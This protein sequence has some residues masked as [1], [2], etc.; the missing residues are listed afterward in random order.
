MPPSVLTASLALG[1]EMDKE[2]RQ[3]HSHLGATEVLEE[4]D[5]PSAR[6]K[7]IIGRPANLAFSFSFDGL[8]W[9]VRSVRCR[10]QLTQNSMKVLESGKLDLPSETPPPLPPTPRDLIWKTGRH[11]L[12]QA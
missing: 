1:Q 12:N 4:V 7:E 2:E 3:N 11:L 9:G 6:E 5:S 8:A 10:Q